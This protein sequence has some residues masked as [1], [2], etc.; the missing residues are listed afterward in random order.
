LGW[1]KNFKGLLKVR[2]II[3]LPVVVSLGLLMTGCHQMTPLQPDYAEYAPT[4][5]PAVFK[6]IPGVGT[7]V[8]DLAPAF[9]LVNLNGLELNLADFHGK[10]VL[11][12]FWTYCSACKEELPYIQIAYE[13]RVSL[14]PDLIVLAVN[15]SQLQPDVEQ[16]VRHYSLTFEILLDPWATVASEYSIHTIPTTFFIDRNGIIQDLQIGVLDGPDVVKQKI[17][18]LDER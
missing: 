10:P 6:R 14:A 18:I 11:L 4:L 7:S 8:G 12:N 15:V 9:K 13:N 3:F 2:I 5:A 17:A 1:S 16:F